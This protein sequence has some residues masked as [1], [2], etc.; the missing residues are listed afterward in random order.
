MTWVPQ[1]GVARPQPGSLLAFGAET[2][3]RQGNVEGQIADE[4]PSTYRVTFNGQRADEDWYAVTVDKPARIHRVVY[5]HGHCFHDGGWFD[6]SQG[7]PQVQ[8]Q[9]TKGGAW[10]TVASLDAYPATTAT[11][12]KGLQDGQAFTA[13]FAPTDAYGVRIIGKPACGDSPAQAFSSCAEVEGFE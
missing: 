13:E 4:D 12:A 1:A 5:A 8:V 2:W 10:E 9:R 11:D 7:K 6:A 3:S